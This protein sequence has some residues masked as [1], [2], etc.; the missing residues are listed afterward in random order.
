V[1][2]FPP[3]DIRAFLTCC[4]GEW[5][6]LRS[7]LALQEDEPVDSGR[8]EEIQAEADENWHSSDRGELVVAY[9]EPEA[10]EAPGGLLVTPPGGVPGRLTFLEDGRFLGEGQEGRWQLWPDGSLELTIRGEET[11]LR[12]RIWFTKA[13]LRLRSSVEHR[14]DGVPQRA[15]F[16]SEIRRV[17][18]PAAAPA[19][20]A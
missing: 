15:S 2:G 3:A 16:S 13:N 18:R 7:L 8:G 19:P 9:L 1:S 17:S 4:A 14:N 20:A 10:P 5:L 12:E 11:L 6:A